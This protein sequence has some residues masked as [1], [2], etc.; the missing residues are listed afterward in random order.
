MSL[1]IAIATFIALSLFFA[2]G[3]MSLRYVYAAHEPVRQDR[4]AMPGRAHPSDAEPR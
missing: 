1:R 4:S 3:L 2:L